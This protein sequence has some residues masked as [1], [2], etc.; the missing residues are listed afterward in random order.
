MQQ[1]APARG[2]PPG[3]GVATPPVRSSRAAESVDMELSQ[4]RVLRCLTQGLRLVGLQNKHCRCALALLLVSAG[5]L[6]F[7]SLVAPYFYDLVAG[8]VSWSD[9]NIGE[10]RSFLL[11][12]FLGVLCAFPLPGS[13]ISLLFIGYHYGSPAG[14]GCRGTHA[15]CFVGGM[16]FL[17]LIYSTAT[18][19]NFLAIRRSC[20]RG[21]NSYARRKGGPVAEAIDTVVSGDQGGWD[22]F[23]VV[24]LLRLT[25]MPIGMQ[26]M[27]CAATSIPLAVPYI[28][29]GLVGNIKLAFADT[30]LAV[31]IRRMGDVARGNRGGDYCDGRPENN[32]TDGTNGAWMEVEVEGVDMCVDGPGGGG[33]GGQQQTSA[34]ILIVVGGLIS[35]L[36]VVAVV[37]LQA[38]R[39]LARME[40][41]SKASGGGAPGGSSGGMA[42]VAEEPQ[43]SPA[44][45]GGAGLSHPL[46]PPSPTGA[47]EEPLSSV[48][49]PAI[50]PTD[51][52]VRSTLQA[53]ATELEAGAVLLTECMTP[54]KDF[55]HNR[56]ETWRAVDRISTD[57][58]GGS[59]GGS[60]MDAGS[61]SNPLQSGLQGSESSLSE[62]LVSAPATLEG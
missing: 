31:H 57:G 53:I 52:A 19:T 13:Q 12:W 47:A 5:A 61:I 55:A 30:L 4:A 38:K 15:T 48:C 1:V 11:V 24:L 42:A 58:G 21:L 10:F 33:A 56:G 35:I 7:L 32:S 14:G 44:A 16:G 28:T 3:S 9:E 26:T 62:S 8:A 50:S 41:R 36:V 60:L 54:T 25:P 39:E 23:Q 6:A 20:G 43:R 49:S 59:D 51:G 40:A 37:G 27:L 17:W 45:S 46:V 34:D 22:S 29:A 2:T 18:I